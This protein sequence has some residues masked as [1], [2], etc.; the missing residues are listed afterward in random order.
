LRSFAPFAVNK[1]LAMPF[2]PHT[3][4]DVSVMLGAIGAASIEELFDEIRPR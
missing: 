3:E 2:I 1:V 4:E